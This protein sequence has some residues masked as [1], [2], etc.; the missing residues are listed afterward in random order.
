MQTKETYLIN[1]ATREINNLLERTPFIT[2]IIVPKKN[3]FHIE[4][5]EVYQNYHGDAKKA[6]RMLN[7]RLKKKGFQLLR[8]NVAYWR[9]L[10][11]A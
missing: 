9:T 5:Y 10:G 2:A 6:K 3:E 7:Y 11:D 8:K 4:P 1:E